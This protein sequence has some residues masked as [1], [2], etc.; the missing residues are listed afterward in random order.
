MTTLTPYLFFSGN[1]REA[2]KFYQK[3]FGGDLEIKTFADHDESCGDALKS[4]VMHACLMKNK[5]VLMASDSPQ[6]E[7]KFC[8]LR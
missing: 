2:M 8:P 7:V 4:N 5:F 1:C 3:Q 6:G